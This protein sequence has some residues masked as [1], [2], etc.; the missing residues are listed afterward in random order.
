MRWLWELKNRCM[1]E[2][3]GNR[4]DGARAGN[5]ENLGWN[6]ELLEETEHM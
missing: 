1:D 5:L 3:C 6:K 2:D 4:L